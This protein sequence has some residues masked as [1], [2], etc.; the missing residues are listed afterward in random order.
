MIKKR[1]RKKAKKVRGLVHESVAEKA[2]VLNPL[3][4]PEEPKVVDEVPRI[5]NETI[6]VHR[7]EVL[8]G[9]RKYIY[10][11]AHSKHRIVLI[12]TGLLV[13]A[14]LGLLVYCV[15]A[16]YNFYQYNTFLYRATQVVPLPIAKAGGKYIAYENYLF[17]LRH[18]VHYYQDQL[19]R[20]F[21]GNDKAQLLQFRRQALD[22][23]VNNAYVKML[24]QQNQVSV[25][26]KEVNSRINEVR[27]QNRLGSNDKVFADVLRDY[28]G[29]SIADFKRS[30]KQEILAEKVVAKIDKADSQRAEAALAKV[31]SGGDFASAAKEL[32]DD[33]TAQQNGGDYGFAITKTNPNVAPQVIDVLYK[34]KPGEISNIINTGSTLEVVKVDQDNGNA[35]FAHHIVINLKD[36]NSYIK[37]IKDKKPVHTYVKF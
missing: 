9:A 10:P 29:W 28:W 11:L 20:N 24:A 6:A 34:L 32:S 31:R 21:N 15:M 26:D 16:L 27:S 14:I 25:S 17:E 35:I 2:A 36:I 1:F 33:P 5:T 13:T 4:T 19:D 22:N 12:T 3:A 8:K 18:Y 23:V 37:E 7:E 30:L